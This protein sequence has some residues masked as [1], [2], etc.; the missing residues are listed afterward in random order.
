M[1]LNF[2]QEEDLTKDLSLH[3]EI[4]NKKQTILFSSEKKV[5]QN[6]ENE[7]IRNIADNNLSCAEDVNKSTKTDSIIETRQEKVKFKFNY[8]P[9]IK[10]FNK[11]IEV[12][13]VGT[14]MKSWDNYVIMKKNFQNHLYE[15]EAFLERKLYFFKFIVNNKWLCSNLYPTKLD[16]SNNLNN[17]IDL[18]NYEEEEETETSLNNQNNIFNF[19]ETNILKVLNNNPPRVLYY[20]KPF[21]L[22]NSSNQYKLKFVNRKKKSN[23]INNIYNNGTVNSCY[24]KLFKLKSE[25][26][27]HLISAIP[28]FS[29]GKNYLRISLTERNKNKLITLVYYKPK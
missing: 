19:Q 17:W 2:F 14:F 24:K 21:N 27:G 18:K 25:S 8:K 4:N 15:Y 23:I 9:D 12:L 5:E 13:L 10:Y 22:D 29:E 28:D 7:K 11:K 3:E 16:E 20:K 6:Q 26:I 1:N